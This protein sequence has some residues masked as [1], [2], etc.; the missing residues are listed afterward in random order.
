MTQA[1]IK[2]DSSGITRQLHESY[3]VKISYRRRA[4]A[5][6]EFFC[7]S[8]RSWLTHTHTCTHEKR[9]INFPAKLFLRSCISWNCW[10]VCGVNWSYRA[11]H[12]RNALMILSQINLKFSE[13]KIAYGNLKETITTNHWILWLSV[14]LFNSMKNKAKYGL[15]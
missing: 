12:P 3:P 6:T 13:T 1:W 15:I 11:N 14:N 7:R 2:L 4:K 9:K 5:Y 8:F 10:S